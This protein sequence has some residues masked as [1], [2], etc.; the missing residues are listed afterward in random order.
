MFHH[1]HQ[2]IEDAGKGKLRNVLKNYQILTMRQSKDLNKKT[3]RKFLYSTSS[4]IATN[5]DG[6]HIL[7]ANELNLPFF[8]G[9][10]AH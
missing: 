1:T 8:N 5:P 7:I 6:T 4:R 10:E 3:L 2:S 9:Q